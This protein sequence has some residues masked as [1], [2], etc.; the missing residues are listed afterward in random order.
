MPSSPDKVFIKD[1]TQPNRRKEI[2]ENKVEEE[3]RDEGNE[4]EYKGDQEEDETTRERVG[5]DK[6]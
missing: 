1:H 4:G 3:E 2:K 6:V 5:E